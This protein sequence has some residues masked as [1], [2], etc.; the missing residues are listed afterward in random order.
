MVW[1][2]SLDV[3]ESQQVLPPAVPHLQ[4]VDV[5]VPGGVATAGHVPVVGSPDVEVAA[6]LPGS[7]GVG[8]GGRLPQ[9]LVVHKQ[10][11]A[12]VGVPRHL[13]VVPAVRLEPGRRHQA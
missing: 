6:V 13:H 4:L 11:Q 1:L 9:Q 12:V 7:A 10:L 2:T 5:E 3:A 8:G